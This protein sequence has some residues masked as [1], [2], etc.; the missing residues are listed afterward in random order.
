MPGVGLRAKSYGSWGSKF[1]PEVSSMWVTVD[2]P[3]IW[4]LPDSALE[5]RYSSFNVWRLKGRKKGGKEG[6]EEGK[7]EKI[8]EG[9]N[10]HFRKS[11]RNSCSTDVFFQSYS[12]TDCWG[13]WK[14][15]RPSLSE[16]I[17]GLWVPEDGRDFEGQELW[18][19]GP[20]SALAVVVLHLVVPICESPQ[21]DV[22]G[23]TIS[24]GLEV[25]GRLIAF[26]GS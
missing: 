21:A 24:L 13:Q 12:L 2:V 23:D 10:G 25:L 6:R 15:S 26:A 16:A 20:S 17:S 7:K 18:H 11:Q 4:S 9:G 1:T 22:T 8:K 3:R 5:K 19:Q 14:I